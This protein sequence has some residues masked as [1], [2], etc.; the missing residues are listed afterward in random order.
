MERMGCLDHARDRAV[1]LDQ[2]KVLGK[3]VASAIQRRALTLLQIR[4]RKRRAAHSRRLGLP[5]ERLWIP[6]LGMYTSRS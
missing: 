1:A 5:A 2:Y 4:E 6:F 3:S